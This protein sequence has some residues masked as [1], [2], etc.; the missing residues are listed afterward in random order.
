M[1]YS[2]EKCN[3]SCN[4]VNSYVDTKGSY[5]A[6]I[7]IVGEFPSYYD[8]R[9]NAVFAGDKGSKLYYYFSRSG[10][11]KSKCFLTYMIRCRV[12]SQSEIKKDNYDACVEYITSDILKIKPKVIIAMG[13]TAVTGLLGHSSVSEFRGHF[14]ELAI[15]YQDSKGNLKEFN[16]V[17]M[18]TY[19]INASM[20]KWEYDDY[21][22]HDFKKVN[23]YIKTDKLPPV[24]KFDYT[25]VKNTK[26]LK[27]AYERCNDDKIICMDFETTGLRFF[28]N[29]IINVGYCGSD[30]HSSIIYL[31]KYENEHLEYKKW[32][33]NDVEEAKEI[34]SFIDQYKDKI[35]QT[36]KSINESKVNKVLWNGKF[37]AKFG[38]YHGIP[39]KNFKHDGIIAHALIDENKLHDLNSALEYEGFDFGAYDT[40]LWHYVGK[41]KSSKKTYQYIPPNELSRYLAI[42]V[43]GLMYIWP[44]LKAKL[45]NIG[46]WDLYIKQQMP[47]V[48]LM[49]NIEFRGCKIDRDELVNMSLNFGSIIED[50]EIKVRKKTGIASL[51]LGSSKQLKEYF[52]SKKYPFEKLNIKKNKTGYSV[53]KET[54]EKFSNIKKYYEIPSLLLEHRI[55]TKLK[56]TYLDGKDKES[57]LLQFIDL[58]NMIHCDS[59]IHTPRTGRLS[60]KD[61]PLHNIPRINPKYPNINIRNLFVP[62]NKNNVIWAADFKQIELRVAAFLAND[63]VMINEI[64]NNVDLHTR[65]C[66]T[67]GHKLGFIDKNIDEESFLNIMKYKK[68]DNFDSLPELKKKK[69]ILKLEKSKFYESQRTFAKSLGFGLNYGIKAETLAQS[70][71]KSVEE[72][73]DM[74]DI[75]FNKYKGLYRYREYIKEQCLKTGYLQLPVTKRKRRFTQIIRW[76][77]SKYFQ[78]SNKNFDYEID[79]VYRQAMNFPIQGYANELYVKGKLQ[80]NKVLKK[81]KLKSRIIL[82]IHDGLVGEG[83]LSEMKRVKELCHNCLETTLGKG[84]YKVPLLIDFDLYDVWYGKEI[85]LD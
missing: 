74:I 5:N 59:N 81:H 36:V 75:Y 68:P 30:Y 15:D 69:V 66:I 17:V 55:L 61:P 21:I 62:S 49:G 79:E 3:L 12:S 82:S 25:V 46:L 72:V 26:Q 52:E 23:N 13:K 16:T 43:C 45:K 56:T 14:Q 40:K 85:K 38:A 24:P 54:L 32:N 80:L 7:M 22:I 41:T 29:K 73:D 71:N 65:N 67:F 4:A 83:P 57:G 2:C 77:K 9:C 1:S 11:R 34:N 70:H 8:D 19:S 78:E 58:N 31:N 76:L 18:P 44:V 50:I 84:K 64:Q 42:D 6:P 27:D 63:K 37:D 20:K 39:I 47:L 28:H 53:D 51:N 48:K 35:W 10:L 33:Q 60:I